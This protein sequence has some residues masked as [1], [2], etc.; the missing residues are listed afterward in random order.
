MLTASAFKYGSVPV[1][2]LRQTSTEQ[3]QTNQPMKLLLYLIGVSILLSVSGCI[4]VPG[5]RDHDDHG[6]LWDHHDG[7]HGDHD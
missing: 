2:P 4:I 6:D 3:I 7:H 1:L 5:D